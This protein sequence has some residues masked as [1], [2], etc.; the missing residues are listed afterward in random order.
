[1]IQPEGDGETLTHALIDKRHM[2]EDFFEKIMSRVNSE[3]TFP[4]IDA[5]LTPA[6]PYPPPPSDMLDGFLMLIAFMTM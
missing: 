5:I 3:Q 1:M 2:T 6:V 4:A